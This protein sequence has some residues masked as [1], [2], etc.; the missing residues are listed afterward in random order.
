[1]V[2]FLVAKRCSVSGVLQYR[3]GVMRYREG[4]PVQVT[5][6]HLIPSS[7]IARKAL[8]SGYTGCP[9]L[10]AWHER[11]ARQNRIRRELQSGVK[12]NIKRATPKGDPSNHKREYSTNE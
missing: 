8:E 11:V 7:E 9:K 2:P 4:Q 6:E 1:M 12:A 5:S 3:G 10:I